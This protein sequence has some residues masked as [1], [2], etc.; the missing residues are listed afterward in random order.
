MLIAT[1]RR[2]KTVDLHIEWSPGDDPISDRIFG[3]ERGVIYQVSA[4]G[5]T[6]DWIRLNI[7]GIRMNVSR[8]RVTWIGEDAVFILNSIPGHNEFAKIDAKIE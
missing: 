4:Y 7:T 5:A 6:L 8:G 1:I 3:L 2:E